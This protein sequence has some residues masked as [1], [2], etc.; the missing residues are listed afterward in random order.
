MGLTTDPTDK[1]LT[2]GVS[3]GQ[4][5]VYLVLSQEELDKGFVRPVR[6]YYKHV[7][8]KPKYSVRELTVEEHERY[9]KFGYVAYEEY[10][11]D[12]GSCVTGRYWTQAQL[13]SGC[14][15]VTTMNQTISETYARNPSFYGSTFCVSCNKHLPVAEFVWVEDGSVVGS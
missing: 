7:G 9:D 8:I 3:T 10:P 4:N 13:N 12:E 6:K 5:E 2:K 11:K 1:L 15:G 14:S